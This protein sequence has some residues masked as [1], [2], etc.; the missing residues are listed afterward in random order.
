LSMHGMLPPP[1]QLLQEPVRSLVEDAVRA[2]DEGRAAASE[3][4]LRLAV[5]T[6]GELGYL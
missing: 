3:E 5:G 1:P 2:W 4:M 6:A